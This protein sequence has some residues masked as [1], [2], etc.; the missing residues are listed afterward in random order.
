MT[1]PPTGRPSRARRVRLLARRAVRVGVT[2]IALL[3]V[4]CESEP[5]CPEVWDAP[6]GRCRPPDAYTAQVKERIGTGAHGYA[7][8]CAMT[9]EDA[10]T[11]D[12]YEL[13][14]GAELTF[15]QV[16]ADGERRHVTVT[17]AQDGTFEVALEPDLECSI[18]GGMSSARTDDGVELAYDGTFTLAEGELLFLGVVAY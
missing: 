15:A 12:E 4:A 1:Q 5:Q 17:A 14:A 16:E 8:R 9:P 10:E 13:A 6:E 3:A 2:G 18:G 11:C 7:L